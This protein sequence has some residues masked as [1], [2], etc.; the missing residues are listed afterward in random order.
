MMRGGSRQL[1]S[2]PRGSWQAQRSE[3]EPLSCNHAREEGQGARNG[4]STLFG[5]D[6]F[7]AQ[8]VKAPNV[9]K[10]K[11]LLPELIKP[12]SQCFRK[13][14]AARFDI[15]KK[16][17]CFKAYFYFSLAFSWQHMIPNERQH[18]Y[19]TRRYFSSARSALGTG[20]VALNPKGFW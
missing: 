2:T 7:S 19:D 10:N 5:I 14:V 15:P 20:E 13:T 1:C 9:L 8:H 11:D 3:M 18:S 12:I 17:S 16:Q 6:S 4:S